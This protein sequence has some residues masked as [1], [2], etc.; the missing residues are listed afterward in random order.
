[1]VKQIVD[2]DKAIL[3]KMADAKQ[4][5]VD[6]KLSVEKQ[7]EQKELNRQ[8]LETKQQELSI[9]LQAREEALKTLLADEEAAKNVR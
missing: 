6:A 8:L 4:T 9:S 1:M 2:H 7:K 3:N 5:I